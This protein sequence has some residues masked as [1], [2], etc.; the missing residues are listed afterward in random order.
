MASAAESVMG[1]AAKMERPVLFTCFGQHE[2]CME[3]IVFRAFGV[4]FQTH[5]DGGFGYVPEPDKPLS[6]VG[7][8]AFSSAF[9]AGH[10]FRR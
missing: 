4:R 1:A 7:A 9:L 6:K 5:Q 2:A 10:K 3:N 8:S